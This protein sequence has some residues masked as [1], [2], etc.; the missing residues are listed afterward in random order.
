[1]S[2]QERFVELVVG[3]NE[4]VPEKLLSDE[5]VIVDV[6]G[7]P[8]VTEILFVL[9]V[10]EKSGAA[11]TVTSIAMEWDMLPLVPVRV[12]MKVPTEPLQDRVDC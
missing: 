10:S 3:D 8:L 12:T 1:V 11:V 7:D 9:V 5:I 4:T 6:A 2:M